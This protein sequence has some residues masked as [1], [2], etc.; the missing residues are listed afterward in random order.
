MTAK[1][2]KTKSGYKLLSGV[3]YTFKDKLL[4]K[5]KD[6]GN[7]YICKF[8]SWLNSKQDHYV[9]LDY[10]QAEDLKKVLNQIK[11]LE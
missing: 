1:I 7:G 11:E 9:E 6:T 4:L 5:V 10:S 3:E 2:I 8:P